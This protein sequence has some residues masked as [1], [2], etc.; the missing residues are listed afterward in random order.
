[1]MN[2]ETIA[3]R[4]GRLREEAGMT[5]RQIADG[6]EG[7]S[8]SYVFRIEAGDR[9]P[10]EKVLRQLAG[11]LGVSAAYLED[12]ERAGLCPHCLSERS[13]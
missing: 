13:R 6:L 4:I 7:V 3:Q 8:Y 1:M 10:S 12:G 11:R 9:T 5:L 2:N